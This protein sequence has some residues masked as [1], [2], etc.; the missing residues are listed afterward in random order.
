MHYV[1]W[2]G[3]QYFVY[4]SMPHCD[5]LITQEIKPSIV[6]ALLNL[7]F[8]IRQG[9]SPV[10]FYPK[11]KQIPDPGM[12]LIDRN[13]D[14]PTCEVWNYSVC[15]MPFSRIGQ[16]PCH[17][18]FWML[19]LPIHWFCVT[20]TKSCFKY[21]TYMVTNSWHSADAHCNYS[22]FEICCHQ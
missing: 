17:L 7:I 9:V 10:W 1:A 16:Q 8:Q 11:R 22:P 6:D 14:C 5:T 2:N 21:L 15:L 18:L 3:H 19:R 13:L 12:S 20:V 4:E